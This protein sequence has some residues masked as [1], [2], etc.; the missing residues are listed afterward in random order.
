LVAFFA[1]LESTSLEGLG[2]G[3]GGDLVFD[4]DCCRLLFASMSKF[5]FDVDGGRTGFFTL[6]RGEEEPLSAL[7]EPESFLVPS[8]L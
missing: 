5:G 8:S 6:I 3:A 4:G 1:S 2:R 7:T